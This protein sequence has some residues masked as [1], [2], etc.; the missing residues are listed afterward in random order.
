MPKY[1]YDENLTATTFDI[2]EIRGDGE[3][4]PKIAETHSEQMAEMIVGILNQ[5][6]NSLY[7]IRRAVAQ[8]E[9]SSH[10]YKRQNHQETDRVMALTAASVLAQLRAYLESIDN[11][12]IQ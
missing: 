2:Y 12:Q 5:G 10:I 7:Q 6:N 3:Y 11:E 9:E 1:D 8:L 4:D